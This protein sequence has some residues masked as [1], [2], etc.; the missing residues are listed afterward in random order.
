MSNKKRR[1]PPAMRRY[2]KDHPVISATMTNELRDVLD[3]VKGSRSYGKAF[4][5]LF[6]EKLDPALAIQ[7]EYGLQKSTL[8]SMNIMRLEEARRC[9]KN[10][11]DRDQFMRFLL[12]LYQAVKGDPVLRSVWKTTDLP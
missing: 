11:I 12:N 2:R 1:Y 7:K 4:S 8:V 5:D 10:N 3:R 9:G 6:H